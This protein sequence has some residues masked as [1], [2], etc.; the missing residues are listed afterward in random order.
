MQSIKTKVF[1]NKKNNQ[2]SIV[3]PRKS[4]KLIGK[5][6]PSKVLLKVEELEW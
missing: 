2:L 1:H 3:L 4:L 6:V 5:K